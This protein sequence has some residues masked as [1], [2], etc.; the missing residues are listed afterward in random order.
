M[1]HHKTQRPSGSCSNLMHYFAPVMHLSYVYRL[2]KTEHQF[3][4]GSVRTQQLKIVFYEEA[5]QKWFH[6]KKY[7]YLGCLSPSKCREVL[8][9]NILQGSPGHLPQPQRRREPGVIEA[10]QSDLVM[11]SAMLTGFHQAMPTSMSTEHIGS[12]CR[13]N[14]ASDRPA[15]MTHELSST[16]QEGRPICTCTLVYCRPDA[17]LQRLYKIFLP[18][19]NHT[20]VRKERKKSV[21]RM[22]GIFFRAFSLF[23]P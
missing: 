9:C 22:M 5:I 10:W 14:A 12:H 6:K 2:P 11:V 18:Q 17:A 7:L 3:S 8:I 23:T 15:V 21:F 16:I 4:Y 20:L 1:P 19:I 13:G